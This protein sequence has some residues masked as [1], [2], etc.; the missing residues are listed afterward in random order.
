MRIARTKNTGAERRVW[1]V[2]RQFGFRFEKHVKSLPGTPDIVIPDSGVI[3]FVNGCFWHHH[4]HCP[5]GGL[6]KSNRL[7]WRKKSL[8]LKFEIL[9][10]RKSL[11]NRDGK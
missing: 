1:K 7:I 4:Y 6:P 2:L 11:L 5:K 9:E 3:I 10:L 8:L